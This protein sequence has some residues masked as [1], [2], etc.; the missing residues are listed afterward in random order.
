MKK[1]TKNKVF[2]VMSIILVLIIII[3]V[4]LAHYFFDYGILYKL[5]LLVAAIYIAVCNS[6]LNWNPKRK[7]IKKK[8]KKVVSKK[9]AKA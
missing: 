5:F 8:T 3:G 4:P 1:I 7:V 6:V 2:Y 9:G